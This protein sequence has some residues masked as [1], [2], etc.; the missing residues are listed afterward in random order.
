MSSPAVAPAATRESRMLARA[1]SRTGPAPPTAPVMFECSIVE[2]GPTMAPCPMEDDEIP[3][4]NQRTMPGTVSR[5]TWSQTSS[6]WCASSTARN[7]VAAICPAG[8][9]QERQAPT[10]VGSRPVGLLAQGGL[11]RR[12]RREP[13]PP[14]ADRLGFARA[15]P[16]RAVLVP[17]GAPHR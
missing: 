11:R 9:G 10:R 12:L 7:A 5:L 8:L 6:P 2:S 17:F 14:E 1:P 13:V 4:A 15:H 16:R 3:P